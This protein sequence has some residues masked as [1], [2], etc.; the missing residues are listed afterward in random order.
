MITFI[1]KRCSS[2]DTGANLSFLIVA[3]SDSDRV[4]EDLQHALADAAGQV[5]QR[6]QEQG[7]GGLGLL[8][9]KP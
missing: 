4:H 2:D 5:P 3:D 6:A 9:L 7:A 1:E 8:A